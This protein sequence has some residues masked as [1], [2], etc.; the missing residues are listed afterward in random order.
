[1]YTISYPSGTIRSDG[2]IIEPNTP[3]FEAY[4]TFFRSGGEVSP[5]DDPVDPT[6]RITVSSYALM[7]AA[8]DMG[9]APQIETACME[10]G[11]PKIRLGFM[12]AKEWNSDCQQ[13]DEVRQMLGID[14]GTCY[15]LFV[16]AQDWTN[17]QQQNG[18]QSPSG[19][20]VF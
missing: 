19:A 9:L 8:S 12:L 7:L 15:A 3:E 5:M 17:M 6:P 4:L 1:M 11:D 10:S 2:V 18:M 20:P 13:V 16:A 14:E